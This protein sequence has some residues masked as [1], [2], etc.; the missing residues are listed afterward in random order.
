VVGVITRRHPDLERLGSGT[1]DPTEYS[2]RR[3]LDGS[4]DGRFSENLPLDLG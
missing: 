4:G 3:C 2:H 1:T